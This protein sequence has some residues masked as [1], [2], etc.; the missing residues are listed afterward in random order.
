MNLS[1]LGAV[2]RINQLEHIVK[3]TSVVASELALIDPN[4][5]LL[6]LKP[7]DLAL[8]EMASLQFDL[9]YCFV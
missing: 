2:S 5:V 9:V 1:I 6:A 7:C 4:D 8:G 3:H